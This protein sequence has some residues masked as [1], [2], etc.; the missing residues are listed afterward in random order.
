MPLLAILALF[1]VYEVMTVY[2]FYKQ[3]IKEGKTVE[4]IP[5]WNGTKKLF[6]WFLG[7][8]IAKIVTDVIVII[9]FV[10]MIPVNRMGLLIF[11]PL[12]WCV[13]FFFQMIFY[14]ICE[15]IVIKNIRRKNISPITETNTPN[16][17]VE[18]VE[19]N[20]TGDEQN[21]NI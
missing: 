3:W 9:A 19:D 8:S 7:W 16:D 1:C 10:L 13:A 5:E 15:T 14:V 18:N 4:F 17:L 11:M 2:R 12:I 20:A 21:D 6:H